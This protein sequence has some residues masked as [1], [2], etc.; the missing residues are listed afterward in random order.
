MNKFIRNIAKALMALFHDI[1]IYLIS[2]IFLFSLGLT[3]YSSLGNVLVK[4]TPFY[5]QSIVFFIFSFYYFLSSSLFKKKIDII[6]INLK[7]GENVNSETFG[8]MTVI[9][10]IMI[11]IGLG[12]FITDNPPFTMMFACL[13]GAI[14]LD[15]IITKSYPNIS[16]QFWLATFIITSIWIIIIGVPEI[17]LFHIISFILL[18]ILFFIERKYVKKED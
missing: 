11:S 5:I 14:I 8:F 18:L 6:T 3:I 16:F 7:I 15:Y 12:F 13:F 1:M 9:G 17:I 10:F 4:N 2:V